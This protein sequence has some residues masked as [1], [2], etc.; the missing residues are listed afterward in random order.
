MI[1]K[2]VEKNNEEENF[3]Q[4]GKKQKEN[5]N[6]ERKEYWLPSLTR[7]RYVAHRSPSNNIKL[8]FF[9]ARVPFLF[10][11]YQMKVCMPS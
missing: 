1:T 11:L 8:L 4:K 7:E 10:S 3:E 5:E 9:S 2:N 6:N